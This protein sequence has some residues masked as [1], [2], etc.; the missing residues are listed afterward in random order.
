MLSLSPETKKRTAADEENK[1]SKK[2]K[3]EGEEGNLSFR[4]IIVYFDCFTGNY[5]RW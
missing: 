3:I 5:Y 1:S 2:M 4:L